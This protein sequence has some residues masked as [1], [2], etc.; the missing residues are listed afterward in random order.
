MRPPRALPSGRLDTDHRPSYLFEGLYLV[1][2]KESMTYRPLPAVFLLVFLM[3]GCGQEDSPD[4]RPLAE[5]SDAEYI[6]QCTSSRT[7]IGDDGVRGAQRYGCIRGST[8]NG[9]CNATV[10]E[11]CISQAP[12]PCLAPGAN[13]AVRT[14]TATVAQARSC[15]IAV[16]LQYNAYAATSCA[17][18]PTSAPRPA[19]ELDDCSALCSKCPG[20]DGCR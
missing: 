14:C 3:I 6:A 1:T 8:F 5:L 16:G 7:A 20:Y 17:I 18:P 11:N 12:T 13:D 15:T 10:F 19:R 4:D 2:R 9:V